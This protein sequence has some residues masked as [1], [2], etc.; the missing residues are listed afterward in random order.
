MLNGHSFIFFPMKQPLEGKS[1]KKIERPDLGPCRCVRCST[2][3]LTF[4]SHFCICGSA[5]SMTNVQQTA[6]KP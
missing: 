5:I 4:S 3:S 1:V 6:G 2:K